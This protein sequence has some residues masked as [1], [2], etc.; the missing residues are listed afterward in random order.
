MQQHN[1]PVRNPLDSSTGRFNFNLLSI[2][3]GMNP[4]ISTYAGFPQEK[5][6]IDPSRS[7]MLRHHRS[8]FTGCFSIFR[9]KDID[10]AQFKTWKS[11]PTPK[12]T[13]LIANQFAKVIQNS[14]SFIT[15]PPPSAGRD[16]LNYCAYRLA[17]AI[18][19]RT[20]IRFIPV[21]QQRLSKTTHGRFASLAQDPPALTW[22]P[23]QH[24]ILL[25]DDCITSCTTMKLCYRVLKDLGNH[26]D[27]LVFISAGGGH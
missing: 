19:I 7:I 3:S 22:Y 14:Y 5:P 25:I 18:S 21:F 15:T 2:A 24:S 23:R 11:D 4:A 27:G 12:I 16:P 8:A 10:W 20:S 13:G 1:A 17:E 6:L 26:I 9:S